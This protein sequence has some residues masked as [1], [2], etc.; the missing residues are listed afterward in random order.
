M[1]PENPYPRAPRRRAACLLAAAVAGLLI[2]TPLFA[3]DTPAD[4]LP[5]PRDLSKTRK[6]YSVVPSEKQID[7]NSASKDRLKT[8][9]GIGDAEADRIIAN[10]PYVSKA[11][12]VGRKV[13]PEGLYISIR[14]RIIAI[15]AE[16]PN[17][18]Q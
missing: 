18:K 7:I 14:Y 15:P 1:K 2:A 16:K 12:L 10:R 5:Q 11:D 17:T 8:L 6:K 3:A 13:L 4:S 9:P